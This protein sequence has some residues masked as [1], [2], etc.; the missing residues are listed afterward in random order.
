[1]TAQLAKWIVAAGLALVVLGG[2]VWLLG[3]AG[4]PLGRLPGDLRFERGNLTCFAP[5]ATMLLLSLLLTL[6]VNLLQ[7]FL[8]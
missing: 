5:L 2:L 1:M 6:A 4:L 7:R 3:R 8:K